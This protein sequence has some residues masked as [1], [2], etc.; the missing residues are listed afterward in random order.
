M[1]ISNP[2]ILI[3]MK[4]LFFFTF[5]HIPILLLSVN[6]SLINEFEKAKKAN[7]NEELIELSFNIGK[8]YHSKRIYKKAIQYFDYGLQ[9][10]LSNLQKAN[11][12]KWIGKV[13]VDSTNFSEAKKYLF[14]SAKL[15]N[16]VK[17][18]EQLSEVYNLTGMCYGLTNN[19]DS[20][21]VMFKKALVQVKEINDSSSIGLGYFNIGLAHYFKGEY[22]FAIDNY[23]ES[24]RIRECL[25]D[26]TAIVT[27]LTTV[28][29]VFRI[30]KDYENALKYYKK[31]QFLKDGIKSHEVLAYI[32]SE[33]ALLHKL[34]K[35]YDEALVYIDTAMMYSKNGGY[36]RGIA[37]LLSYE[38]G[39]N[40]E[41][42]NFDVALL[43]YKKSLESYKEINFSIGV[44]QVQNA[45]ADIYIQKEKFSDTFKLL[46]SS[47]KLAKENGLLE[48]QVENTRLFYEIYKKQ[49]RNNLALQCHEEYMLLKDSLFNQ[50]KEK[51]IQQ[52]EV[53]YQV[54]QK[55][56]KIQL[57]GKENKIQVQKLKMQ[58]Y[59]IIVSVFLLFLILII[60]F[61]YLKQNKLRS[62]LLIEQNRQKLLRSQMNPHF[63]YNA[64]SAIQNYI[65]QKDPIDSVSYIAEFSKLM[66]LVLE[67]SRANLV[68][69]K[70]DI[71]LNI[72]YIRLQQLRFDNQFKYNVQVQEDLN[73]ELI[74]IPPMLIQ[75]FIE[76]SIEHGIRKLG[77][78]EGVIQI[79]YV[80][81]DNNLIISIEDNGPGVTETIENEN[82]VSLATKITKERIENIHKLQN[83]KISFKTEN[84]FTSSNQ[85]F[86]VIVKIPLK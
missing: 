19:L 54:Q 59:L 74:K 34:E 76:N 25:N 73:K 10:K 85:G 28:G 48:E 24:L 29:E 26:T 16:K 75:P 78:K 36:K 40:R 45:I 2:T 14:I 47:K 27:S 8:Q 62:R 38:A 12:L 43:L 72:Y 3:L 65:L 4:F 37:T 11:Y 31:A 80:R 32:Y 52:I 79:S 39:I 21:I 64:L 56:N 9:L 18:Y 35:K 50:E 69:L 68:T 66:R 57:L 71:D 53:E 63:I 44:A 7:N 81:I 33:L 15:F 61:L 82:H 55:E 1:N 67:G 6:D 58:Q 17:D 60:A 49:K 70:E 86:K 77:S 5:L 30:R 42:G 84:N 23:I 22:K 41:L 20:A 13:Y 51:Q 83:L 46:S